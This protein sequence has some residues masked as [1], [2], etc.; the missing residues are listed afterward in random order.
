MVRNLSEPLL[1]SKGGDTDCQ[2]YTIFGIAI[3][4]VIGLLY[5]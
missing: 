2:V 1:G 3:V 5:Y 4:T